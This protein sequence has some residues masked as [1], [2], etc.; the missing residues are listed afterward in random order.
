MTVAIGITSASDSNFSSF[1]RLESHER[2]LRLFFITGVKQKHPQSKK[3]NTKGVI[4]VI[5]TWRL[6]D[7]I[8]WSSTLLIAKILL[9]PR[10]RLSGQRLLM[11][12]RRLTPKSL[13]KMKRKASKSHLSEQV[14]NDAVTEHFS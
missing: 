3:R 6:M 10:P 7:S 11:D 8:C 12:W 13:P 5:L 14:Q 1:D 2:N 4:Y 9:S